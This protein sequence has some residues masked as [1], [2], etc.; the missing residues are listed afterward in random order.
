[1]TENDGSWNTALYGGGFDGHIDFLKAKNPL[2]S[3]DENFWFDDSIDPETGQK[4]HDYWINDAY[5]PRKYHGS[6]TGLISEKKRKFDAHAAYMGMYKKGRIHDPADEY[7]GMSFEQVRD[8]W[9]EGGEEASGRGSEM[10]AEIEMFFNSCTNW[11]ENERWNSNPDVAPSLARFLIFFEMEVCGKMVPYRTELNIW[12]EEFEFCGQCDVLFQLL[13]W[14]NDPE[15]KNWVIIGDWKRTKKN[16]L[17]QRSYGNML[18]CCSSLQDK[19][20]NHYTLQMTLYKLGLERRTNLR[21]QACYLGIFHANNPSYQWIKVEPLPAI[22]MQMLVERRQTL[23]AKYSTAIPM[24]LL[25]NTAE[26]TKEA[27]EASRSLAGLLKSATTYGAR[28]VDIL[29]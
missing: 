9:I 14:V 6:C 22:A 1:M 17:G 5:G 8:Q 21:V 28:T 11:I 23:L 16:L 25:E 20:I 26:K 4:R 18:G 12:D 13:E 10:H 2:P 24:L 27:F 7:Y 15:K 29:F 3:L 19:N